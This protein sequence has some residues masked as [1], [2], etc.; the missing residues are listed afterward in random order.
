MNEYPD[1]YYERVFL[2]DEIDV[3]FSCGKKMITQPNGEIVCRECDVSYLP[4]ER[5]EVFSDWEDKL[6]LEL[7]AQDLDDDIPEGCAACGGPWPDCETS[8][9][10]FD[11]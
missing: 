1:E 2:T 4:W 5:D 9:K 11:D 3:C 8:C 7:F 10:L 6:L